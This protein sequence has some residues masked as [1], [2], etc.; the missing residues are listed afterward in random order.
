MIYLYVL[1]LKV[2]LY[3]RKGKTGDYE[4]I[5]NRVLQIFKILFYKSIACGD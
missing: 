2:K 4:V 5:L 3:V 1:I